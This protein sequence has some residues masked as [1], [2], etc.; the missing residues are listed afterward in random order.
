MTSSPPYPADTPL[1]RQLHFIAEL[2]KLKLVL[3]QSLVAGELRRENSAEHSWHLAMM[4]LVL[5][6]HAPATGLDVLRVLKMALIH[7]IV[8]IDA[9][10]T[11]YYDAS[12]YDT[13]T[14]REKA[15]ADRLFALLPG[16]KGAELRALWEEFEAEATP[17][18]RWAQALDRLQA[19][20]Q[21][22]HTGGAAWRRHRVAKAD[23]LK[24]N[25]KIADTVPAVWAE[26]VRQLDWAEGQGFFAPAA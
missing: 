15:A 9:G 11:F 16:G 2:D 25:Q 12:G 7:D 10:D 17:E 23:V 26:L 3:R 22:L 6:E 5:L 21:N 13:K 14:A 19:V 1:G 24:R 4:T 20:L 8:E 18:S